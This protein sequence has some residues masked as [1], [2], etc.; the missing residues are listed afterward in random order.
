ML[1]QEELDLDLICTW[2]GTHGPLT[3]AAAQTPGV[4]GIMC[5]KPMATSLAEADAMI[6]AAERNKVKLAIGHQRRFMGSRTKARQ[7]IAEGAIG[8]PTIIRRNGGGG[9]MN[10]H[11]H[12][13][14]AAR[15][16]L[17]DP[18]TQWVI[19]QVER[20][21]DRY[22]RGEMIEDLCMLEVCFDG[23]ARLIIESDMPA[24]DQPENSYIYG[25]EGILDLQND[26]VRVLNAKQAEWEEIPCEDPN[27]PGAQMEE[28]LAWIEGGPEHRSAP[29][30]GR[31]AVE[32]M[33]AAYESAR[34][35]G[36]VNMPLETRGNPL[37]M[38][39][40]ENLLPVEKP[41]PY[42][43]RDGAWLGEP[44]PWSKIVL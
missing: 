11:T 26:K 8:Q 9:L 43:I 10:S 4:K 24:S 5:E 25:T 32:I 14:D 42:D 30:H 18:G 1:D 39:I 28:L 20:R 16:Y 27:L 3:V 6:G 35:Q 37:D 29:Q 17:G 34:I 15:Y 41:G 7:L 40:D 33:M 31:A 21:T 36:L 13:I 2:Q 23:G 12:N 22:E 38:M 19:G 44:R